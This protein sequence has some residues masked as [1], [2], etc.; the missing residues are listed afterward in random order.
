MPS[1]PTRV[2]NTARQPAYIRTS[3]PIPI[4]SMNWPSFIGRS[5]ESYNENDVK[6]V[7]LMKRHLTWVLTVILLGSS[8]AVAQ[9]L[10]FGLAPGRVSGSD[11]LRAMYALDTLDRSRML[12]QQQFYRQ[13]LSAQRALLEQNRI[14]STLSTR[15]PITVEPMRTYDPQAT[16]RDRAMADALLCWEVFGATFTPAAANEVSKADARFDGGLRIHAIRVGGPI[17]K[18]DWRAGDILVGL[19]KFKTRN[20]DNLAYIA[21]MPTLMEQSPFDYVLV[22]EGK[23]LRGKLDLVTSVYPDEIGPIEST[24]PT[25]PTAPRPAPAN[26]PVT[27]KPV[28][29]PASSTDSALQ[30]KIWDQLGIRARPLV[31]E[32]PSEAFSRG[33]A[34]LAVRPQSPAEK[35]GVRVGDKFVALNEY[36]TAIEADLAAVLDQAGSDKPSRGLLVRSTGLQSVS[37]PLPQKQSPEAAEPTPTNASP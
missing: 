37:I 29:V 34:V 12:R 22:R 4:I 2:G 8:P 6:E 21:E 18:V 11:F 30:E 14:R 26:P 35:A 15:R 32:T 24:K 23:I 19:H 3:C 36:K 17:D 9:I 1:W 25:S 5:P 33:L 10:Y 20:Y 13:Q 7:R 31:L 28:E 27:R 16:E